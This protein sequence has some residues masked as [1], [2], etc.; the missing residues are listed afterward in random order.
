MAA[1]D[2]ALADLAGIPRAG[3]ALGAADAPVTLVQYAD[4]QCPHCL[5]H[6]VEQEPFLVE[7]YVRPGLL[8]I[9]FRHF[10]VVG[11]ESTTAARGSVCAAA[12]DRFWEYANRLF[13]I[14]AGEGFRR[15][16]GAFGEPALTALAGE[17]GLDE[18]AFA[19]CLADPA[20][21]GAVEDD[22]AT[23]REIGF[24]GTPAFVLNDAPLRQSAPGTEASW[25]A[26]IDAALADAAGDDGG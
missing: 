4:F 19:A 23:G 22:H 7:E 12:Q 3:N 1:L 8:R 25:R 6:A 15:D 14:Q 2:A 26:L 20:T 11:A 17:L 13:A 18:G 16:G 5:R 24:Q 9:E 10:P 21:L